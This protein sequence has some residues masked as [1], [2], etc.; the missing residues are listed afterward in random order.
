MKRNSIFARLVVSNTIIII[1]ATLVVSFMSLYISEKLIIETFTASNSK[2]LNETVNNLEAFHTQVVTIS[3]TMRLNKSFKNLLIMEP[4]T[5]LD[6]YEML[7]DMQTYYKPFHNAIK[8]YNLHLVTVGIN[9]MAYASNNESPVITFEK[10]KN[11]YLT[12]F[13]L[14]PTIAYAYYPQGITTYTENRPVVVA[15]R[16]LKHESAIIPY[17]YGVLLISIDES[18]LSDLYSK[19]LTAGNTISIIGADGTIISSSDKELVGTVDQSLYTESSPLVDE[20]I[21]SKTITINNT[22]YILLAQYIPFLDAHIINTINQDLALAPIYKMKSLIFIVSFFIL[23]ITIIVIFFISRRIS[24]PLIKMV[25]VM[26][27][28]TQDHFSKKIYIGGSHEVS[29]LGNTYNAM[30]DE[31]ETYIARLIK[32]QEQRRK[33]ELY[34]LQMQINPH[35]LYN[36]LSAIKYL[37]WHGNSDQVATTINA[38]ISLLQDTVGKVDETIT[39][40]DEIKNLKNYVI[41]AQ[42]RY[43]DNITVSYNVPPEALSIKV[44]KLILQPFVENAFFHGFK[45]IP[46]GVIS[47]HVSTMNKTLICEIIDSGDGIDFHKLP[48]LVIKKQQKQHFTGIGIKNVDERIKLIYGGNY[49]VAITSEKEIGTCVTITLPIV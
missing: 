14:R 41:I 43:G 15:S 1:L 10:I 12:P 25:N 22:D 47:I 16:I 46:N 32:E 9:G 37:S 17:P 28:T 29:V 8:H 6:R 35:F 30:L 27:N 13:F 33:A 23:I 49:G 2:M 31:L 19:S 39:L 20:N 36:T 45:S 38:L 21:T 5:D 42:T 7:Y 48:D 40:E 3:N 26:S 44:P 24:L 4:T 34:A 18:K 11:T